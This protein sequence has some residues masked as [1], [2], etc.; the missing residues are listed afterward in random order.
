MLRGSTSAAVLLLVLLSACMMRKSSVWVEQ[1]STPQRVVF[2][3]A[4]ER[5]GAD[6]VA[7]LNYV[8]VRSCYESGKSQ[9]TFWQARGEVPNGH[10]PPT[11]IVYGEPPTGFVN[12]ANPR[13][14][15][16]GCYEGII[17]GNGISGT[18]RF[19]VTADG[20]VVEDAPS[21]TTG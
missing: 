18:A 8:A 13:P 20:R 1:G 4:E 5:G 14:L 6:P 9:E 12:E 2:G 15:P 3:V 17:S 16:P 19:S 7:H 10:R 21:R 11:R